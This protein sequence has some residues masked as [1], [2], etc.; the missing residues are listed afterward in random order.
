MYLL[1]LKYLEALPAITQGK[2]TTIFLPA[3]ATGVMG[4]IGGMKELLRATAGEGAATG[5]SNQPA[6]QPPAPRPAFKSLA[7]SGSPGRSDH[8]SGEEG[9]LSLAK[10]TRERA[11]RIARSHACE[12]CREYSYKKLSK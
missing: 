9:A 2:G 11:E 1:G 12:N 3:E 10:I 4:A 6:Y 5:G 7:S 8:T